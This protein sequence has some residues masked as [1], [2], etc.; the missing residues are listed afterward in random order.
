MKSHRVATQVM[1]S[2]DNEAELKSIC[3][4]IADTIRELQVK[5]T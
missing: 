3:E 4:S 5:T 2:D 1:T